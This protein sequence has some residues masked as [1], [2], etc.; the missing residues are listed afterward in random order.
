MIVERSYSKEQEVGGYYFKMTKM[1]EMSQEEMDQCKGLL[2]QYH[3]KSILGKN[4]VSLREKDNTSVKTF[5]KIDMGDHII[6][7]TKSM[8]YYIKVDDNKYDFL[9]TF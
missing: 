5:Y 4:E 3:G 9:K 8:D 6:W 7:S 1:L 2:N